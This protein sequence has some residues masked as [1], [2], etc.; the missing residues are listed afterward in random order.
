MFIERSMAGKTSHTQVIEILQQIET[1]LRRATIIVDVY[2]TLT[3]QTIQGIVHMEVLL[4]VLHHLLQVVVV[5]YRDR[6]MIRVCLTKIGLSIVSN[7]IAILIPVE[8]VDAWIIL[9]TIGMTLSI[10]HFLVEF[11]STT[12]YLVGTRRYSRRTQRDSHSWQNN[13]WF[14]DVLNIRNTALEL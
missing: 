12:S 5:G 4:L 10:V 11:P 13:T 9:Y 8:R 14:G 7:I 3:L 2:L 1:I 6:Y